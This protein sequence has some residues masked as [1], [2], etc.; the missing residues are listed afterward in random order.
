MS[1]IPS[2]H[3]PMVVQKRGIV[4]RKSR[5]KMEGKKVYAVMNKTAQTAYIAPILPTAYLSVT[6][7]LLRLPSVVQLE[8]F[9][10]LLKKSRLID[11]G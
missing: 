9:V 6:W 8:S 5:R 2:S 3:R 11:W 7:W 10:E 1:S 4:H